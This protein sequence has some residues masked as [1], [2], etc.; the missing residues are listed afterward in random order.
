[1][2][3]GRPKSASHGDIF[4]NCPF[5][6]EYS[7]VFRALVFAILACRFM[8]RCALEIDDGGEV[9]LEKI[10]RLMQSCQL[11]IHDISRTEADTANHLPRFNMPFELG[12]FL[13]IGRAQRKHRPSLVLDTEP[14]RYQKFLSDIAGQ[15]I[16]PHAGD[17][18][19]AMTH[20]RNWLKSHVPAATLMGGAALGTLY[21]QF[22][23]ELP[24][25]LAHA[26]LEASEIT[27]VD[28][29]QLIKEWLSSANLAGKA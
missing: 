6:E 18:L 14:Y 22:T 7:P 2:S 9:R 1:M 10:F 3:R 21:K 28:W 4:I 23:L 16:R 11:S 12:L 17:P 27:F 24:S 8:P 5:D 19:K 26:R 13:G 20:V 29:T 15:D 25:K